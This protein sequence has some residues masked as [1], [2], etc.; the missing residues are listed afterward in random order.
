MSSGSDTLSNKEKYNQLVHNLEIVDRSK[1]PKE[2]DPCFGDKQIRELAKEY[3]VCVSS[4]AHG[5]HEYVISGHCDNFPSEF[6]PF[7]AAVNTL[8]IS[9]AE[10]ERSFSTITLPFP[11]FEVQCF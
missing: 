8:I 4:S 5:F 3:D 1:W 7:S 10:C 2:T 11:V 6:Q 9:T